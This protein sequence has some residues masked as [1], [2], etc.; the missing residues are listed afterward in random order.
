MQC[1]PSFADS[2]RRLPDEARGD[3]A[4]PRTVPGAKMAAAAAHGKRRFGPE[5]AQQYHPKEHGT[6]AM[7]RRPGEG[8]DRQQDK[9]ANTE[10]AKEARR[11]ND[12]ADRLKWPR[13]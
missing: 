3:Y 6:G 5:P 7:R 12:I 4:L 1:R 13:I 8:Y 2:R 10:D 11:L 9:P